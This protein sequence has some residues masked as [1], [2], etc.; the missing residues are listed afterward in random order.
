MLRIMIGFLEK[1]REEKTNSHSWAGHRVSGFQGAETFLEGTAKE[2]LER[3][4][5]GLQ[6]PKCPVRTGLM[7]GLV[8]KRKK[9]L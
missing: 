9:R 4:S 1:K 2:G 6:K 5:S 7:R 8:W 3:D